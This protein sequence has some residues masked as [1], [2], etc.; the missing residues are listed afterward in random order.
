MMESNDAPEQPASLGAKYS[1]LWLRGWQHYL[2]LFGGK[3]AGGSAP[4]DIASLQ[5][6]YI[7][8]VRNEGSS[9]FSKLSE[10]SL[11]YYSAVLSVGVG[12]T[13]EFYRQIFQSPAPAAAE[14][15]SGLTSAARELIF[16]GPAGSAPAQAFRVANNTDKTALMTFEL[17]EFVSA[18]G[19]EKVRI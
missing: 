14:E 13:Q 11:N 18:D 4:S 1:E 2:R 5:Q 10:L 12:V 17:S 9:A 19:A 3:T 6:R 15:P 8:F 16:V 7:E